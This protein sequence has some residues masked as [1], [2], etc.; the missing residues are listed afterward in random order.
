MV[1]ITN[2]D[3]E[4]AKQGDIEAIKKLSDIYWAD[5][6]KMGRGKIVGAL[7]KGLTK[8][9]RKLASGESIGFEIEEVLNGYQ[10]KEDLQDL[11]PRFRKAYHQWVI[12]QIRGLIQR[13]EKSKISIEEYD[14]EKYKWR[15]WVK[16]HASNR[17]REQFNSVF[18]A[19]RIKF[20]IDRVEKVERLIAAHFGTLCSFYEKET[21]IN[22]VSG[23]G[24]TRAR[25]NKATQ[26]IEFETETVWPDPLGIR[27]KVLEEFKKNFGLKAS[28]EYYPD[29]IPEDMSEPLER[30]YWSLK[31]E[32]DEKN[33]VSTIALIEKMNN[34]IEREKIL[35]AEEKE[36]ERLR[37]RLKDPEM[38]EFLKGLL[39][40]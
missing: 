27:E 40:T 9:M 21:G 26:K 17:L 19:F 11:M 7:I 23:I 1:D 35:N 18:N 8:A 6:E 12:V 31:V 3:L 39:Q 25:F 5:I 34:Q 28:L 13:F 20:G 33:L 37:E 4:K 14:K 2:Q 16:K 30:E 32:T 24:H 22:H 29:Y 15:K 36:K 38:K 10:F